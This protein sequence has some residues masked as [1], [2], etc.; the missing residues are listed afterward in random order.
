MLKPYGKRLKKYGICRK[1]LLKETIVLIFSFKI[2]QYIPRKDKK[3]FLQEI[4]NIYKNKNEY[5][6]FIEYFK[7]N[8]AHSDFLDFEDL[9]NW[10]IKD[11]MNN[12]CEVFHRNLIN[13]INSYHP[14]ISYYVSKIK[15]YTKNIFNES[16]IELIDDRVKFMLLRTEI[17]M[18]IFIN[19]LNKFIKNIKYYNEIL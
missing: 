8:W 4:E 17:Y 14:K 18:M 6:K 2:Y 12:I 13:I 19:L 3:V 10:K 9:D 15:D 16:V 1:K 11:R 5:T 7:K